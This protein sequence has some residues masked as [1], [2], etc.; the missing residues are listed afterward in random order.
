MG[1][2]EGRREGGKEVETEGWD[3]EEGGG[4]R[5]TERLKHSTLIAHSE[6]YLN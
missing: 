5:E 4:W 1:L 3:A 2:I 6:I